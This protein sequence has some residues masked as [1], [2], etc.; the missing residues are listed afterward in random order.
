MKDLPKK[1]GGGRGHGALCAIQHLGLGAR[2]AAQEGESL[3][4]T[5]Y[6]HYRYCMVY[7]IT[8]GGRWGGVYRAIVVQ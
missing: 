4:F 3:A 2:Q 8:R 6:C 1:G 7:G 5:R